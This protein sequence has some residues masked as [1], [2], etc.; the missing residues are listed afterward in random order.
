MPFECGKLIERSL[1]ACGKPL[2]MAAWDNADARSVDWDKLGADTQTIVE[3]EASLLAGDRSPKDALPYDRYRSLAHHRAV[4]GS[5]APLVGD[6]HGETQP[7][8]QTER[9]PRRPFAGGP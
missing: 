8:P 1:V 7:L 4:A 6:A 3:I 5:R 2:R 9:V